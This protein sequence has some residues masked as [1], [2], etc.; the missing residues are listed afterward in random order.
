MA[1]EIEDLKLRI[2]GLSNPFREEG[3]KTLLNLLEGEI[4]KDERA[5]EVLGK[6]AFSVA[7]AT[8]VEKG[9]EKIV[10]PDHNLP[11]VYCQICK[12]DALKLVKESGTTGLEIREKILDELEEL[13]ERYDDPINGGWNYLLRASD[14]KKLR[15]GKP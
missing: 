12:N 7:V 1:T 6:S 14:L 2:V 13:L 3:V 11:L 4:R 9:L 10:C 15:E 8:A 5:R